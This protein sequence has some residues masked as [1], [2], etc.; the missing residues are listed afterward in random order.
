MATIVEP[1]GGSDTPL[2]LTSGLLLGIP[3]HCE[4]TNLLSQ[5]LI[6]VRVRLLGSFE[7]LQ[8]GS[9]TN[10]NSTTLSTSRL[11]IL[12]RRNI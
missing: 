5:D 6:R 4:I 1:A 10:A 12:M 9:I 8:W 11:N 7:N 2:E 3:M